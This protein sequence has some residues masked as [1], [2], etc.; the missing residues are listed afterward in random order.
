MLVSADTFSASR[1]FENIT[2]KIEVRDKEKIEI[3][4]KIVKKNVDLSKL[5]SE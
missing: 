1:S 5:E 2:A 4:K 3:I